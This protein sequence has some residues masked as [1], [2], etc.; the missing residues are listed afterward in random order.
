ML[1]SRLLSIL[2]LLQTRGQMS[3]RELAAEFEV[4][5]RTIHRDI[6]Q[7]SA[8]G[9]PVYAERGRSGGFRLLDGYRTRLTGLTEPEA[10]ALFL[11][12]LPGPAAQL[13][14]ADLLSTARL[15][16][17]AALPAHVQPNAERIASRFHLDPAG[18]FRV[19][20]PHPALKQVA[21]AVWSGLVLKLDYRRAGKADTYARRLGPLG[22]VLKGGVWYLVALSGKAIR[23]Y[24][25]ANISHVEITDEA[26]ERPTSFD[27]AE[28]WRQ[29]SRAYE[30]G[31]YPDRAEVRISPAGRT[32]LDLLGPQALESAALTATEPDTGSWVRC[33][34]PIE[35][36]RAGVRELM[37]L[38]EDVEILGPKPLREAMAATL[39]VM[40]RR[41]AAESTSLDGR[42]GDQFAA[43][44]IAARK[45]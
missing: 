25:V 39:A 10:E 35:S 1:A 15:K 8:A 40:W 9:V 19:E 18:W 45:G 20:N 31:L 33:V 22:L 21:Q 43:V 17:M 23:T 41:H 27:L 11:A 3:A 7:L 16:L 24:R 36:V 26:F 13:G 5:E 29:A 30:S 37:R 44:E 38:G 42:A 32:Q 28:H 12:G 14:L 4:S 34:V 2:M 6:D